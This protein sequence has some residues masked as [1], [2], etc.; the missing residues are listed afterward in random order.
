MAARCDVQTMTTTL[1]HHREAEKPLRKAEDGSR[2]TASDLATAQLHA[3][4]L[5]AEE[6]RAIREELRGIRDL[7]GRQ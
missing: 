6:L 7:L 1:S 4:L 3:Q 2:A 5:I